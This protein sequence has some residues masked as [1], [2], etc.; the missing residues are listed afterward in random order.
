VKLPGFASGAY[1]SGSVNADCQSC[2][3]LYPEKIESGAGVNDQVL[4]LTPGLSLFATL[5][6]SPVRGIWIGESRCFAVAGDTLYEVFSD[7][8]YT[9]LGD[10]GDDG[11]PVQMFPNGNQLVI[12]S[13]GLLYCHT[14][15]ELVQPTFDGDTAP[16][17]AVKGAFLDSYFIVIDA[18]DA[19]DAASVR[20]FRHSAPLDG[21][22]WDALDFASKEGYP[23]QLWALLADHEDLWLFGS[24][25]TEVW[26]NNYSTAP[27]SFPWERDPGAFI[28]YGLLAEWTPSRL[29]GGIAWLAGDPRGNAVAYRAQGYQPQRISTHAIE[30]EWATYS[31][32]NDAESYSYTENGHH[33]WVLNFPTANRTWV[34]D[35]TTNLWHRRGWWNGTTLG[36]HRARC[37]GFV[38]GK[39]LVGDWEN[40]KIYE[41]STSL[42]DDDGTAIHWERTCP[43]NAEEDVRI[44]HSRME[45]DMEKA[46]GSDFAVTLSWSNDAGHTFTTGKTATTGSSGEHRKRVVWN[47]IG[48]AR[49]RVYRFSGAT[50]AKIA[51]I[52]A[53]LSAQAGKH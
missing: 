15:T 10:V 11:K 1:T 7:A 40:G 50:S 48:S 18:P 33:F 26:R 9:D 6:T 38:F 24:Q 41:M 21:T 32:V 13:D 28:H 25:T 3:N 34:Y 5:P 43:H 23:D 4:Y 44:F 16:V 30:Q 27:T 2:V 22:L 14:G 52:N 35:A 17:T 37:H 51:L 53:Y 42:Y 31:T 12:I 36:R 8:T 19:E 49:D 46:T 39:H 20:R 47:R 45:L 29:A